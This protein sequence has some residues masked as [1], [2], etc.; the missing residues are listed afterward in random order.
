ME[1]ALTGRRVS[2]RPTTPADKRTIF[3]WATQSDATPAMMGPPLY[4]DNLPPT[5]EEFCEDHL[6]HF[7]DGSA[8][9]L[10]RSYLIVVNGEAVGQVYYNDIEVVDGIRRTELDIWMR[11]EKDCGHGYGSEAILLLCQHLFEQ[12]GVTQF[13]MQPSVR[14]PRA[15]RAYEK[16]GFVRQNLTAGE[17]QAIWGV[18]DYFDSVYM[19]KTMPA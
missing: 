18:S 11:S 1:Q 6:P 12:L 5:W 19:V 7:F 10:G 14:N 17:A 9:E 2:L 4:P 8:P 16:I 13:M 15:I 3:E